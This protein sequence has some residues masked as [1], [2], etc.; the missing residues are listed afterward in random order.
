[1]KIVIDARMYGLEHAGIG[2]YILNL[3]NQIEKIDEKNDYFIL[4]RKKYYQKLEFKNKRFHKILADWPHYSFKEQFLLPGILRKIK[5]DLVHFPHFNVPIFWQGKYIVTIHDLIKHESRGR[6]TT[7]RLSLFYWPKYWVYQL[8]VFLAIKRAKRIITPSQ[9]WQR[10]LVKRYKIK[11]NKIV[12]T[13]EGAGEFAN[14]KASLSG[15][16]ALKK[17]GITKPFII[18]TGSLY[19]HKNVFRL[20]QAVQLINKEN[21]NNL[22]LVI[23]SARNVFM[24]RFKKEV[25][26][27]K[28][29][30][31]VILAGFVPDEELIALYQEAEAFVTPSLL[32]GFCLTGLEA[33]V[34]GLPVVCSKASCLPEIYGQAAVYFNP[35]EVKDMAERIEE[36]VDNK[37]LQQELSKKGYQQ[38][39]KYSWEKMARETLRVYES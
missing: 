32:E 27:T 35:L 2:R 31:M 34:T 10:E 11:Q 25:E 28:G 21:K 23:A 13:Y 38:V 30:N 37:K 6:K 4:L 7:T 9:Y 19:P 5:P 15:E 12:V 3:I 14:K 1:M 20:V 36:V 39:K 33:M 18:Y 26:K 8:I 29:L 16:K 24:E 22:S 17:Y